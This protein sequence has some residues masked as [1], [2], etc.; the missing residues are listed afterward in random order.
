MDYFELGN[1]V[2]ENYFRLWDFLRV[3]VR[4]GNKSRFFFVK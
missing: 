3:L 2:F 1:G 4:V